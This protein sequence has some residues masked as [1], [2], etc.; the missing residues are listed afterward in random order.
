MM[1]CEVVE[2][3]EY[4]LCIGRW[5]TT[6]WILL[7]HILELLPT[8]RGAGEIDL[9]LHCEIELPAWSEYSGMKSFWST[10]HLPLAQG[11]MYVY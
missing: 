8:W 1:T 4:L 3:D 6:C 7:L 5:T 2:G 9:I 10:N 11:N